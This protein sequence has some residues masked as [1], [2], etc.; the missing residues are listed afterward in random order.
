MEKSKKGFGV[1]KGTRDGWPDMEYRRADGGFPL[2]TGEVLP[3]SY[4]KTFGKDDVA[5]ALKAMEH[6]VNALLEDRRRLTRDLHDCILQSLYAIG[7]TLEA[8]RHPNPDPSQE[9][10]RS[11]LHVVS[12][13]NHL[14]HDVRAMIESL[15]AGT[16]QEFDFVAELTSLRET[17]E[18]GGRLAIRLDLDPDAVGNLTSEEQREI[19]NI[20]REALSNCARHAEATHVV[21]ALRMRGSKLRVSVVDDGRG[22]TLNGNCRRGYGLTNMEARARKL[23]GVLRVTSTQGQGTTVVIDLSLS[24]VLTFA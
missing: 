1:F 10:A 21:V 6:R 7:L 2:E 15:E 13:L 11:H 4:V 12:Q 9:S 19:L 22:F 8:S 24:S 20:V 17:Y 18:Q 5:S 3:C 23:G 16:I 14:I